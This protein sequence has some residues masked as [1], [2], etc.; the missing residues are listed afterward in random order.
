MRLLRCRGVLRIRPAALRPLSRLVI[1]GVAMECG[2]AA[3][4][5]F[6][7]GPGGVFAY[8]GLFFAVFAGYVLAVRAVLRAAP[9]AGRPAAIAVLGLATLFRL[10]FLF[11]SPVLSD[12]LYRYLWDGSVTLAGGNPY[13]DAPAAAA[14]PRRAAD[15]ARIGHAEVPTIYPPA[16]QALF[17]AGAACGRGIHGIKALVVLADLLVIAVLLVLLR[18]RRR[19]SVRVLVYAWNPLAVTEAAW[20]GHVEPAGVL[21]VLLAAVAI[22]QKREARAALLLALGGLVK[23]LPLVLLAPLLRS[24]RA[25]FLPLVLLLLLAACWPFRAAGWRLLAGLRAYATRWLGNESLFGVPHAAIAWIDPAPHLKAAI[26]FV[27]QRVPHTGALD[28]LYG[29]VYPIDLAKGVC[30]LAALGFAAWL[31]RRGIEPLRGLYLMTGAV[32]LLSPTA[33]PWYF[34]WILPWLCLF[35]SQPWILL[36]GLVA[37]AYVNLGAPGRAREPYPWIRIVEYAPFFL[38]LLREWLR[39]RLWRGGRREGGAAACVAGPAAG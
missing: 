6:P 31:V 10:T 27:R 7:P 22:I 28:Y 20:S 2:F 38:L 9:G 25:R 17:A 34:L 8:L 30:A 15:L 36:S 13:R 33:H 37:L 11:A 16:A 24:I 4:L 39:A 26:A 32:L 35:P 12:D 19:P 14:A 29:W 18:E 5:L 23:I 3:M 1:I 21:C